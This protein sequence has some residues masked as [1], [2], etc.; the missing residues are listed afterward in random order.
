MDMLQTARKL[1]K[2]RTV[3]IIAAI[4]AQQ[5]ERDNNISHLSSIVHAF[6]GVS[7]D[8]IGTTFPQSVILR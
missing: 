2:D 6:I 8:S 3:M 5:K 4:R 1:N 7:V